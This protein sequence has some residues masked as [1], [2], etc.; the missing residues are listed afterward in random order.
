MTKIMATIATRLGFLIARKRVTSR[1]HAK[2]AEAGSIESWLERGRHK[3]PVDNH[4][5]SRDVGAA[6]TQGPKRVAVL[7]Q[8]DFRSR[9]DQHAIA[10]LARDADITWELV[11]THP[12][13]KATLAEVKHGLDSTNI[14]CFP[15]PGPL[16]GSRRPA[17]SR[18]YVA[19]RSPLSKIRPRIFF[20]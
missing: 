13:G 10:C 12:A 16:R 20:P 1:P 7:S 18:T 8:S 5:P 17:S 14:G 6:N 15:S 3:H 19:R 2:S 4:A 11:E 9:T